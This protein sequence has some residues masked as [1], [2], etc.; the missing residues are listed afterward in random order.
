MAK[1]KFGTKEW[2][3]KT[4]N[5]YH[6]CR[7]NCLYCYSRYNWCVRYKRM[8]VEK[9][10]EMK[11]NKKA[12]DRK[13]YKL[14]E[15]R[16][17]FPS[18]HDIFPETVDKTIEYL[19]GWLEVGNEILITTKPRLECVGKIMDAFED[20]KDQI[21]WR[22]T[23]TSTNEQSVRFWEPD[24]PLF[25]ERV[26][27]LDYAFNRG[28]KTS[29]SCE[30]YLDMTIKPLVHILLPSVTDSIWIGKMNFV[31][32]RV[33]TTGWKKDDF[34]FL[35]QVDMSQTDDYIKNELYNEFKDNPKIRWKD[36]IK[37]VLNLPEEE[38]G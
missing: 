24:A 9:W 14:K 32:Q 12:F 19:R 36:S 28:W 16:I 6:G 8:K 11:F 21:V 10:G 4:L 25:P 26:A 22:F 20:F 31:E 13:P 5:L 34:K 37:K 2:A 27:S 35:D 15:G 1:K 18:Q 23:I 30:P 3:T 7:N 29:V 38:I 33:D 17:M